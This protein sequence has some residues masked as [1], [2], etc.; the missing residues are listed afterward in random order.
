MVNFI[1]SF[2]NKNN[3]M[4]QS[5]YDVIIVGGSY[6]GLSAAMALG[7]SLRNVL[8]IDGG[9]P[10]NRQTVQ[11]HNFITQDGKPPLEI[12]ETARAEVR[13]YPTITFHQGLAMKGKK[14]MNNFEI[15]TD[16]GAIFKAKKLILATGINDIMPEIDGFAACWGISVLHCPYCHGYE[17]R[18]KPTGIIAN[19]AAA[20]HY[21][22]LISNWTQDLTLFT[23]G[24]SLLTEEESQKLKQHNIKIIETKITQLQHKNGF[25]EGVQLETGKNYPVEAVYGRVDFVQKAPL[26]EQLGC[27]LN[28]NGLIEV[29]ESQETTVEGVYAC[30]DN[31]SKRALTFAVASGTLAGVMVNS[32]LIE[33]KFQD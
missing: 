16:T 5:M 18:N 19:G 20:F 1:G 33:A 9:Q 23:N 14:L 26:I 32:G 17:V 10:C 8:L 25:V 21:A 12:A 30:G 3:K 31:S 7:R 29:N 13:K 6:A 27:A 2:F 11:S 4:D 28:E 24:A 22:K 15:E